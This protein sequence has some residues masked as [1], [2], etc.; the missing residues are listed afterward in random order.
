MCQRGWDTN[1]R[2]PQQQLQKRGNSR[3]VQLVWFCH[4]AHK[5]KELSNTWKQPPA[6]HVIKQR[7]VP[8]CPFSE[9]IFQ[10]TAFGSTGRKLPVLTLCLHGAVSPSQGEPRC[11][12]HLCCPEGFHNA[13]AV[14]VLRIGSIL[15]TGI[16]QKRK[17]PPDFLR[18]K[19]LGSFYKILQYGL[20]A[21]RGKR[22]TCSSLLHC[23]QNHQHWEG[24]KQCQ[25]RR[26]T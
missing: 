21:L 25:N 8:C 11:L 24:K 1:T 18:P 10:A 5:R 26:E 9:N 19:S 12:H 23:T 3:P 7:Q 22:R 15:P 13:A 2:Q 14:E 17:R 6:E 4:G 16:P 20:K